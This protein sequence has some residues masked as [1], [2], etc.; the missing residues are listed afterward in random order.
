M[1]RKWHKTF[2]MLLILWV[3]IIP[4]VC[5]AEDSGTM[6]YQEVLK[7]DNLTKILLD[8]GLS[9]VLL[10]NHAAPVVAFQMWVNVG[11]RYEED[12]QAGDEPSQSDSGE[13]FGPAA[14]IP[15]HDEEDGRHGRGQ[16]PRLAAA[17]SL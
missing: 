5:S 15:V 8:N 10:E 1:L 16:R 9:V 7:Q 3:L 4:V 12:D 13:P 6:G 2:R 11:S 14:W 17:A